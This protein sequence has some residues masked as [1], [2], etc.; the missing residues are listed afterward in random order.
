MSPTQ[1]VAGSSPISITGSRGGQRVV[2][3][4]ALQ[5]NGSSIE[6]RSEWAASFTAEEV[7]ALTALARARHATGELTRPPARPPAPALVVTA[8]KA[9]PESDHIV[10]R[11]APDTSGGAPLSAPITISAKQEDTYRGLASASAAGKAI[12][13]GATPAPA[14]LVRL[15]DVSASTKPPQPL[16][17]TAVPAGGLKVQDADGGTLFTIHPR[18]GFTAATGLKAAVTTDSGGGS[19]TVVVSY[20]SAEED[21]APVTFTIQDLTA[22]PARVSQLVTL[23]APPGGAA[24]PEPTP[25]AG[26]PLTGGGVGVAARA[27]LHT[28]SA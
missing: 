11:V 21:A 12:G 24:V 5:F 17:R 14:A 3:L 19:F 28:P 8:A 2:P 1:G 27:L 26:V 9:G 16:G 4:S 6:V 23:T 10:V 22:L 7:T 15:E 13:T 25:S 18:A 20:D